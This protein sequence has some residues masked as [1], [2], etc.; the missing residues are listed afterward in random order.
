MQ[1]RFNF[2]I[3]TK[4]IGVIG[5]PIKQ[6]LSPLMHNSAFRIAG[7]NYIYLP[8][9]I[10]KENLKD[11]L[12]S[13]IALGLRG[14]NVTIPLK[15]KAMQYLNNISEEASVIGAVNTIVNE[16]GSLHGY[17]TDVHGIL[18][19]LKPYQDEI[20]GKNVTIVGAGGA[21]RSTIYALIRNFKVKKIN[22][23]NRTEQTAE[24]LKDYFSTKMHFKN[25]KIYELFPPEL[26]NVFQKSKLIINTSSVGMF[27]ETDD[28]ITDL[29]ESF[30]KDQIVFDVVYNPMLTS[31][32][33]LAKT[34]GVKII[35][36]LKMF[37]EQGAK[38]YE[39]WTGE[40]M[41][42]N[43]VYT[44]L[45]KYLKDDPELFRDTF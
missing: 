11:A 40:T 28:T 39:I 3:N 36:G 18:E 22:I 21:A 23:V 29:P 17:N 41:P 34:K 19:A 2:D 6:S 15:E 35:N 9:D 31:F 32:L 5:H 25:F 20:A 43:E 38:S 10:P 42:V 16:N 44:I 12:N 4:V 1:S 27:P 13:M 33:K 7:L 37:V 8:F 14:F 24:S 26:I 30:N 45:E